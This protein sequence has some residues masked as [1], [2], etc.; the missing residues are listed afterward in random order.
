MQG[1][2]S[3]SLV[4]E[5][6]SHVPLGADR[7]KKKENFWDEA[8]V[9]DYPVGPSGHHECPYKRESEEIRWTHRVKVCEDRVGGWR[10]ATTELLEPP[11]TGRG[12]ESSSSCQQLD[13]RL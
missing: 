3:Q 2:H 1:M 5:L 8:L 12:E 11:E 7:K 13:F 10:E 4:G 9:L 6:G